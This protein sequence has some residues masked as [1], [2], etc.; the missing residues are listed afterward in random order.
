MYEPVLAGIPQG[1]QVELVPL[2]QMKEIAAYERKGT[3]SP[4]TL[5]INSCIQML[6]MMHC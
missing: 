6:D 1:E 4:S 5:H 2:S 3:I